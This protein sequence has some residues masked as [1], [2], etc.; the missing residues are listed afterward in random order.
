MTAVKEV[1]TMLEM[2]PKKEQVFAC[3]VMKKLILA[4]DPDFT[5]VTPKEAV[6]LKIAHAQI[7]KGEFFD[8]EDIDWDNLN[9]MNL[10]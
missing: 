10:D 8:D 6:E 1:T 9:K 4:W 5:K 7:A 2:L 3:E